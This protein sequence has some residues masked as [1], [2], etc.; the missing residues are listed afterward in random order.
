MILILDTDALWHRPLLDAL[1]A[2]NGTGLAPGTLETVLPAVAYAERLRQLQHSA[3]RVRAFREF[4]QLAAVR[5]EPFTAEQADR[6]PWDSIG[7]DD[8]TAHARDFLI[9]AH[10]EG[11]RVGVTGDVGPAWRGVPVSPPAEATAAVRALLRPGS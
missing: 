6:V 7:E 1:V 3:R 5:V 9:A 8:W 4:L 10:I 11:Q 2:A